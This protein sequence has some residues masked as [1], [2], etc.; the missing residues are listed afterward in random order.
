[1]KVH[2]TK[3]YG[4]IGTGAK[5]QDAVTDI[6]KRDLHFDELGIYR[7]PVESDSPEMLRARIDGIIASVSHGDIV[8]IQSPTWNGLSFDEGLIHSLQCYNGVKKIIFIHDVLPLMFETWKPLL[9]RYIEFYNQADLVIVASQKMADFLKTRGLT[10]KKIIIHR[11]FDYIVS[12]DETIKPLFKKIINFAGNPNTDPKLEFC[13]RWKYNTVK[14][15]VT[16]DS[17]DWRQGKKVDFLGWFNNDSL[18]VN[19]LRKNGGFGLLWSE[20]SYWWEYIK[21]N[22]SYKFSAYLAAGIPVIVPSGIAEQNTIIQKNLGL[23][24]DSL[25][26]AVDKIE[27]MN[28]EEYR[29]MAENA[30]IFSNL[31]RNGYFTRKALTDAVFELLSD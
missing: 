1:M 6:A 29:K 28:E 30:G 27:H 8:I 17:G 15:A 21:M 31:L 13:K 16:V 12:I 22:A 18:L 25:D 23:V 20:D 4:F 19:A 11:M 3:I 14:L 2:I 24:V 9:H 5:A 7:Y 10:V 26:E